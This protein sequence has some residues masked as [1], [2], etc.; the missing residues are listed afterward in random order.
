MNGSAHTSL[1]QSAAAALLIRPAAF[2]YNAEAADSNRFQ[3]QPA[4]AAGD[5][6]ARA[7]AEFE[8]VCTALRAEGVQLCVLDDTP[9]P[10]KPDAVFPNNWISFHADG[11]VVLYPMQPT[12]RRTERRLDVLDAVARDLGFSCRVLHDLRAHERENRFLEGTG[13]LVLD[14]AQRVAYACRS[15]RTDEALVR[16]WCQRLGYTPQVFDAAD[17]AGVPLYHTNVLLCIGTAFVVV[18]AEA[19]AAADRERVL[20]AL[21]AS[22]REIITIDQAQLRSFG[23]NMLELMGEDEAFSEYRVLVMSA[24]ARAAFHSTQYLR[25]SACVDSVLAI[26][27]PTIESV[28]GGGVRCMLAEVPWVAG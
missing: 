1:P 3:R 24:A 22:G 23:A 6:A 21:G 5:I 11:S 18:G 2:G 15:P 17:E 26:P 27:I 4:V 28:G 9:E 10:A 7:R 25:L 19:I 20:A 13:S 16:T 8:R 12:S 14:H